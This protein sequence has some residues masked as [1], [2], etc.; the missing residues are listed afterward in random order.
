MKIS[1]P[2]ASLRLVDVFFPFKSTFSLIFLAF[3]WLPWE[4][5]SKLFITPHHTHI[6][7]ERE[8]CERDGGFVWQFNIFHL[9]HGSESLRRIYE[10]TKIYD[11]AYTFCDVL[12]VPSPWHER[13]ERDENG[14]SF[15]DIFYVF[16]SFSSAT[17]FWRLWSFFFFV[18]ASSTF[19]SFTQHHRK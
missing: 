13:R 5:Y 14:K 12:C 15:F 8:W 7:A 19:S 2:E 16:A 4:I 9:R 17:G 10:I 3:Q 6:E 1:V 11:K 18:G